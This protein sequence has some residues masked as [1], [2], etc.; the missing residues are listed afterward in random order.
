MNE[1][2]E[3]EPWVHTLIVSKS[4][5]E[6]GKNSPQDANEI[7]AKIATILQPTTK[8]TTAETTPKENSNNETIF[9]TPKLPPAPSVGKTT[10]DE[11]NAANP[12]AGTRKV[13]TTKPATNQATLPVKTL[14]PEA[15]SNRTT[16]VVISNAKDGPTTTAT[17]TAVQTTKGPMMTRPAEHEP[18][19]NCEIKL[20]NLNG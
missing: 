5:A 14:Y 6:K 2:R 1:R 8:P 9:Y 12:S 18:V 16:L 17:T 11:R 19:R 15:E 3:L 4:F 10:T 7:F 20:L 13:S